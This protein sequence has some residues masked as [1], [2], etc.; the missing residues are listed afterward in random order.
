MPTYLNFARSNQALT[1]HQRAYNVM[2][3]HLGVRQRV[4]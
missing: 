3:G 4:R 2:L 1:D